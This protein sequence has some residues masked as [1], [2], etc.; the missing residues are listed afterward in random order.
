[1]KF[2]ASERVKS[3][4]SSFESAH[5]EARKSE[6]TGTYLF[7]SVE[8]KGVTIYLDGWPVYAKYKGSSKEEAR[9]ATEIMKGQTGDVEVHASRRDRVEMFCTYMRYIGRDNALIDVYFVDEA[10]IPERKVLVTNNNTLDMSIIPPGTRVGYSPDRGQVI[11]FFSEREIGG[12]ALSNDEVIFFSDGE[13][14]D[15]ERFK[16]DGL[17]MLVRMNSGEGLGELECDYLDLFTQ[18]S[19][20]GQVEVEF[21]IEGWEVVKN[22]QEEE[23]GGILSGVFGG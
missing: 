20:G 10:E 13:V 15:R 7:N 3:H 4:E 21:D 22:Q 11:D 17:P 23:S 14:T 18:G 9:D 19:S 8:G 16:N 12:Y 1:M 2:P 6:F 5:A